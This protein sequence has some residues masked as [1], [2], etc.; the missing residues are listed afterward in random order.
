MLRQRW[1]VSST[2]VHPRIRGEYSVLPLRSFPNS[3]SPPHTRGIYLWLF[4]LGQGVRFTPA[5]AGNIVF[6]YF[7]VICSQVHPRIRGEYASLP[8]TA[9]AELGSPPHTRGIFKGRTLKIRKSR[10]TPAYAGNILF[11][12]CRHTDLQVHPR[13]RGEYFEYTGTTLYVSGSPPHTRGISAFSSFPL[14]MSRFTPAYA[15]NIL[16]Q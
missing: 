14:I 9:M 4:C 2:Q 11:F 5:Y 1:T 15:G 8:F 13:I 16:L 7:V 10:F 6:A 3:G 12:F